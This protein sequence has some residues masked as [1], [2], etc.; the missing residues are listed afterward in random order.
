MI[1]TF[2]FLVVILFF[3]FMLWGSWPHFVYHLHM[4]RKGRRSLDRGEGGRRLTLLMWKDSIGICLELVTSP[5]IPNIYGMYSTIFQ[6]TDWMLIY[7]G[8]PGWFGG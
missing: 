1:C 6:C 3:C 4:H 7:G 8:D 5:S 2:I